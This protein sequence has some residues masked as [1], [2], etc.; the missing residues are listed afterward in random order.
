MCGTIDALIIFGGF[1]VVFGGFGIP[2][3]WLC[4]VLDR[5]FSL[6]TTKSQLEEA[7]EPF[8][9]SRATSL[10]RV[11]ESGTPSGTDWKPQQ[12]IV[13]ALYLMSRPSNLCTYDLRPAFERSVA[14]GPSNT[15]AATISLS[16][17]AEVDDENRRILRPLTRYC[18]KTLWE[19]P[20]LFVNEWR[21]TECRVNNGFGWMGQVASLRIH[22][23]PLRFGR[24]PSAPVLLGIGEFQANTLI[25]SRENRD[26]PQNFYNVIGAGSDLNQIDPRDPIC[27]LRSIEWKSAGNSLFR[28]AR[29]FNWQALVQHYFRYHRFH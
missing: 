28:G 14:P 24:A 9:S 13:F 23:L 8:A 7:P 16:Y 4:Y 26:D 19:P 17:N 27:E 12:R 3:C 21:G 15:A 18:P 22:H 25:Y 10:S 20:S 5:V 2:G 1:S 29:S 6:Q 11:F